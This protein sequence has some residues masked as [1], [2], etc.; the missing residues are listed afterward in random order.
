MTGTTWA[1]IGVGAVAAAALA[2]YILT[3]TKW[4]SIR[5]YAVDTKRVYDKHKDVQE[6]VEAAQ[7]LNEH[8][9]QVLR[10]RALRDLIAAYNSLIADLEKVKAP[11]AAREIH[12]DTL[13]MNRE[14]VGFYQVLLTGGYRARAMQEKQKKLMQMQE[15]LQAKMEKLY[16][17]PKEKKK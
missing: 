12:Q 15:G 16:G 7:N 4:Y 11:A 17:K 1:I 5:K 3:R 8:T 6:K 14:A 9:P 2:G 10:Q 13:N